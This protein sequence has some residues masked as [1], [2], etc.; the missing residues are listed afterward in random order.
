MALMALSPSAVTL[1]GQNFTIN[2]GDDLKA[3]FSIQEA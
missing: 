2:L 3:Q 1:G